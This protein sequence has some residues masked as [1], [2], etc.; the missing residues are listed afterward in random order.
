MIVYVIFVQ[1][2]INLIALA[3]TLYQMP[4]VKVR[5]SVSEEV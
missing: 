5:W 1:V 4:P 3:F 2:E